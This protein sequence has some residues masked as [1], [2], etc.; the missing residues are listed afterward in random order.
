M[1]I[2]VTGGYGFLGGHVTKELRGREHDVIRARSDDF[3]LRNFSDANEFLEIDE[4]D[5]VV[6]CAAFVGGI[7]LNVQEPARMMYDNLRMGLN[8]V[9]QARRHKVGRLVLVGT[10]CS[11]P[12]H[13]AFFPIAEDELWNGRPARD[14]G[15]YGIAKLTLFEMGRAYRKAYNMK[16]DCVIPSNLYGPGDNFKPETAHVIPSMIQ[17]FA[18]GSRPVKLWGDGEATRDFLYVED[19][20][21]GIADAVEQGTDGSPVNLGSGEETTIHEVAALLSGI[22]D[23]APFLFQGKAAGYTGTER[24]VLD[25][26]RAK[27]ELG[28]EP[29][30]SLGQGLRNTVESFK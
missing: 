4:I 27:R 11:Y 1:R 20:A 14:T 5:A 21:R 10:A 18:S 29:Q 22:Y 2:A 28:W 16:V 19:A 26:S 17:K 15:P 24:R 3:D 23:K 12:D 8:V 6:H 9:E 30:V 7:Q 13:P 25:I